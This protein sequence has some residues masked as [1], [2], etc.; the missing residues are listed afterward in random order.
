MSEP[1]PPKSA[2]EP[3]SA[4]PI[5]RKRRFPWI[6][7]I[8]SVLLIAAFILP[9]VFVAEL[10]DATGNGLAFVEIGTLAIAGLF[11]L[12]W[13]LWAGFFSGWRWWRRLLG[14]TLAMSFPVAFLAFFEPIGGDLNGWRWKTTREAMSTE[15]AG[16]GNATEVD[17]SIETDDDFA[18]YLGPNQNGVVDGP[19]IDASKFSQAKVLWKKPIGEGWSAFAARNGFAVTMEQ[20]GDDE[21]V[22]CY[23]IGSGDLK[24]IYTHKARHDDMLG[25]IGPRSTPTIHDG[26]VYI[27]GSLGNVACLN[28]SDGTIVWQKSLREILGIELEE[29]TERGG[30]TSYREKHYRLAWGR[31]ASPLIVDDMVVVPGGGPRLDSGG[32]GEMHTLIAFDKNTGDIKWKGGD[33]MI[34]YASPQLVTLAGQRQIVIT[35]EANIMGFEPKTGETLWTYK[36]AGN[37]SQAAN[38]SQLTVV[39][40]NQLLSA[41]GY[42][43]G[44][45]ELLRFD[46]TDGK[47]KSVWKQTRFLKTKLTSP[48]LYDGHAYALTN[49]FLE[50]VRAQDGEKQWKQRGRFG[51]GQMLIVGDKLLLHSEGVTRIAK[52]YLI[53]PSPNGYKELGAIET[54]NGICWNTLCLSGSKLLVRSDSEAACIE[55]PIV[56]E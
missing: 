54:I 10:E 20:R 9:K 5:A 51:H 7:A 33:K 2:S 52:L 15:I 39:S 38:T 8:W 23:E 14:A 32:D 53:D 34:G 18:G 48:L 3:A 22:T 21:C 16:G 47:P 42:P 31:S 41:K 55:L 24:W 25:K 4:A 13:A 30:E 46:T 29:V 45:S 19:N 37:S 1:Q 17:L 40:D 44:G 28:G 49:G 11:F 36:R 50:C 56:G 12:S 35:A 26:K 27:C 6:M 43:D